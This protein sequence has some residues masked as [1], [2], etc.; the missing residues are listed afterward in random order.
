[1]EF[2]PKKQQINNRNQEATF[3]PI[4][5]VKDLKCKQIVYVEENNVLYE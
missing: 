2:T 3:S 5:K 4:R 1:M